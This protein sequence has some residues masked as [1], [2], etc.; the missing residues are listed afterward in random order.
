MTE[1]L[2]RP[3]TLTKAVADSIRE[4]IFR[5]GNLPGDPLP[6]VELSGSLGV[7]RGTVREALRMLRDEGL[8]DIIPHRGAFVK[9]LSSRTA[10]ELYTLRAL[11]EPYA[12]R[13]AL[14]NQAYSKQDLD[15]L[16][17][18][19]QR[20]RRIEN[21]DG[22]IYETIE[23]DVA[24]HLLICGRSNHHLLIETLNRLQSLTRLFLF[25]IRLYQSRANSDEPTHQEICEA[26]RA[27]DPSHAEE[28]LRKH[29]DTSGRALLGQ[30]EEVGL[31]R[32]ASGPKA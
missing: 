6:E 29:I 10:K 5:G 18:L 26:V 27:G 25:N 19:A 32:S 24:F 30:M 7:A 14:E 17:M 9:K 22:N 12:V 2:V 15:S 21:A 13:L 23:A 8:V 28:I 3:P 11:L 4:T 1:R 20:P 16:E 31:H